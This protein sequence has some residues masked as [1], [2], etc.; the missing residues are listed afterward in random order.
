MHTNFASG[1][2]E[3]ALLRVTSIR[4]VCMAMEQFG[5]AGHVYFETAALIITLILVG[6]F[7]EARGQ[8][9]DQ[10]DQGACPRRRLPHRSGAWHAAGLLEGARQLLLWLD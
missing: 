6:K 8:D 4:K 3:Q 2:L 9:A 10:D 1:R 5:L 7:L